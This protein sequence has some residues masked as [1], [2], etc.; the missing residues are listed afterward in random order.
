M[1][2]SCLT[3]MGMDGDGRM[4]GYIGTAG[5]KFAFPVGSDA[6]RDEVHGAGAVTVRASPIRVRARVRAGGV[7]LESLFPGRGGHFWGVTFGKGRAGL[8]MTPGDSADSAIGFP[9]SDCPDL[10]FGVRV[11]RHLGVSPIRY[12]R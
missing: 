11:W 5:E 7:T 4:A 8:K 9:G 10:V 2:R 1:G 6:V 3:V 12:P